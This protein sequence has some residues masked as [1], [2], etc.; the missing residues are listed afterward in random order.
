MQKHRREEERQNES[1]H[2]FRQ[3]LPLR[4]TW[5]MSTAFISTKYVA[6]VTNSESICK[7]KSCTKSRVLAQQLVGDVLINI[8]HVTTWRCREVEIPDYTCT[9][10]IQTQ[11]E[12][13]I[14]YFLLCYILVPANR[15]KRAGTRRSSA[16]SHFITNEWMNKLDQGFSTFNFRQWTP[17]LME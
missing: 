4:L 2:L 5:N 10:I 9:L 17:D 15:A 16:Q 11:L 12:E 7:Q 8:L 14:K 3:K 6:T 13:G 1:L